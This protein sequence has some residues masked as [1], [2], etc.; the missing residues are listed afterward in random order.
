MFGQGASLL[1]RTVQL[2]VSIVSGILILGAAALT[3]Q[4]LDFAKALTVP[5]GNW[6]LVIA[7][8]ALVFSVVGLAWVHS[9]SDLARY[10]RHLSDARGQNRMRATEQPVP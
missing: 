10:Q 2:V 5:D 4:H 9:S 1:A 8:A 6:I 3:F 7:G